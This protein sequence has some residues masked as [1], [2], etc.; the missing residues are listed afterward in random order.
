M[1][2]H[3]V[4]SRQAA[5]TGRFR[6]HLQVKK[7]YNKKRMFIDVV[8][9]PDQLGRACESAV[10]AVADVLRATTTMIS[11]LSGGVR[12][13]RPFAGAAEARQAELLKNKDEFLSIV[14]HELRTP[15]TSLKGFSQLL[16]RPPGHTRS[17]ETI[18]HCL[19][20]IDHQV[21]RMAKLVS[22]LLDVSR[23]HLDRLQLERTRVN[24]TSLAEEV[25]NQMRATTQAHHISIVKGIVKGESIVKGKDKGKDY[26]VG[27]WDR[28]RISQVL[29]NLLA[30][31]I[32]YS[33]QGGR[34][35]VKIS[36]QG[37]E[38]LVAIHDEGIGITTE[39]LTHLFD[40]YYRS[41]EASSARA[42][43][44]GLGLFVAKGIIEA[45]QGRIWVEST[46]GEGSTFYFTLP[47]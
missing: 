25:V 13:I 32:Q 30:N 24:L 14:A 19:E 10:C 26:V 41:S 46:E 43:G 38:A 39:D 8:F 12:E 47:L 2:R 16:L 44:M 20:Q 37:A 45:H 6:F 35:E 7:Q 18:A 22:D 3:S 36:R 1:L 33:P 17:P 42:G 29:K 28:D 40:R 15:L 23:I 9:A 27:I 34:I 21:D 11:A 31:A 5:Y 4:L